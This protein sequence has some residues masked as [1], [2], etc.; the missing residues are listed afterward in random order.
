MNAEIA[1]QIK[2]SSEPVETLAAR[3]STTVEMVR[4]IR[5][6][7]AFAHIDATPDGR[8]YDPSNFSEIAS[9]DELVRQRRWRFVT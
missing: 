8:G 3:Y 9:D 2:Q 4:R 1:W 6:G 5:R 7:E